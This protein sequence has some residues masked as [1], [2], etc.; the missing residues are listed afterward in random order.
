MSMTYIRITFSILLAFGLVASSGASL[1]PDEAP[2]PN[3]ALMEG[4]TSVEEMASILDEAR[5]LLL[6][7]GKIEGLKAI[8]DPHGEFF[9]GEL[10]VFAYDFK[11]RSSPTP[12]SKSWWA[13]TT[14]TSSTP[15]ASP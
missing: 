10:Y 12:I 2:A 9:R 4:Q 7:N 6:E 15:T 1:V 13:E 5:D 14:S 11:G 8:S 3:L